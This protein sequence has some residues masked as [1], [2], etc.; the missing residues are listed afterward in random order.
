LEPRSRRKWDFRGAFSLVRRGNGA[1]SAGGAAMA[2]RNDVTQVVSEIEPVDPRATCVD[3]VCGKKMER[4]SS[5]FMV[6]RGDQ[7]FYFCSHDCKERFS[8]KV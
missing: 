7:T 6:F 3:P 1:R 5:R 2:H 4:K 8:H